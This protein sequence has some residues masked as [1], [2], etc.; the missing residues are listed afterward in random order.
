VNGQPRSHLARLNPD[1]SVESTATFVPLPLVTGNVRAIAVQRDGKILI[2]GDFFNIGG[3]PRGNIA[4]LNPDGTVE[5]TLTFDPGTGANGS[6]E[7]LAVQADG[8]IIIAGAFV[9]VNG[10]TRNNIA[11]LNPNGTLEN[12]TTFD[13][14][15]GTNLP[16]RSVALQADGKI[17]LGGAFNAVDSQF[18]AQIAR[19]FPNGLLEATTTFNP[20]DLD[21]DFAVS[22]I[23]VQADG[24]I[25]LAGADRPPVR[26][27]SNGLTDDTFDRSA[28]VSGVISDVALQADGRILLAGSFTKTNLPQRFALARLNNGPALQTIVVPSRTQVRWNRSGTAP[29]VEQVTFE[30]STNGGATWTLLGPGVRTAGGWSLGGLSLP[31]SGQIRA[32]GRTEAGASGV[33]QTVASFGFSVEQ[34]TG[35]ILSN[36]G[37]R[38]FSAVEIG[39]SKTLSF[40]V[41]NLGFE[42]LTGLTVSLEGDDQFGIPSQPAGTVAAGGGSTAFTVRF[43]PRRRG[44]VTATIRLR[45]DQFGDSTFDILLTAT[46]TGITALEALNAKLAEFSAEETTPPAVP[47]RP[48]AVTADADDLVFAILQLSR[49]RRF[50]TAANVAELA[51]TALQPVGGTTR[52]DKDQVAARIVDAALLGSGITEASEVVLIV[53]A[54]A[55][56]NAGDAR[57]ALSPAGKAAVVGQALAASN[58]ADAAVGAALAIVAQR[59]SASIAGNLSPDV[60]L[61]IFTVAVLKAAAGAPAQVRGFVNRTLELV[62]GDRDAFSIE[63]AVGVAA[64]PVISGEVLGVRA[65][66]LGSDAAI[67]ERTIAAIRDPR[68]SRAIGPI[69]AASTEAYRGDPVQF[70]AA[71]VAGIDP[72]SATVAVRAAIA[73]GVIQNVTGSRVPA[74]I[75]TVVRGRGLSRAELAAF[76][77]GAAVGTGDEA[78]E[79]AARMVASVANASNIQL[80]T[81]IAVAVLRAIQSTSPSS[82]RIVVRKLI[83][84][85]PGAFGT[86][87]AR[88]ALA[89]SLA[90]ALNTPAGAAAAGAGVAGVADRLGAPTGPT[91]T[92]LA[93]NVIPAAPNAALNI[94]QSL[95]EL[96]PA[97]SNFALFAAGIAARVGLPNAPK[98]AAGVA[99]TAAARSRVVGGQVTA[100][101][102]PGDVAAAVAQSSDALKRITPMIAGEIARAVHEER[103]AEIGEAVGA[104][105]RASAQP[106]GLPGTA[107]IGILA[108]RLADAINTRPLVPTANRVDELAELSAELTRQA[109]RTLGPR[110]AALPGTIS[111]IGISVMRTLSMPLLQN[112]GAFPADARDAA[113]RLA[114]AIAQTIS[115]AVLEGRLPNDRADALLAPG[116]AIEQNLARE[117][118][119]FAPNVRAAFTQVRGAVRNLRRLVIGA[120]RVSNVNTGGTIT[121]SGRY[122]IGSV[123]DAQA[124]F[125]RLP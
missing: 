103:V 22:A 84:S 68:L 113:G 61:R 64:F 54:V 32:R 69:V 74:V 25:L 2:A 8:K 109:I 107:S 50:A 108:G 53:N 67:I 60:K 3:Q 77:G 59:L 15:A 33:V 106:G 38:D 47:R 94:A 42:D 51:S 88:T 44:A 27:L 86:T 89:R 111:T 117:A 36:G 82:G 110:S 39:S 6:I 45:S 79:V 49:A 104:L 55:D 35:V 57:N 34:P 90:Q 40:T 119:A 18:R 97:R 93:V 101:Q 56:V 26:L 17:L 116:G 1:G 118:G 98:V 121:A 9:T 46:G 73:S 58:R 91:L 5:S 75:N 70:A 96:L 4:R 19:L 120:E 7:T 81:E 115:V 30:L 10:Q 41:R 23:A 87:A 83:D 13:P 99:L 112:G 65:A 43:T 37:S 12:L 125:G 124:T 11:R 80:R 122:E 105:Y 62:A 76:A 92:A 20:S 14:G 29:E 85:S 66:Q 63:V 100:G 21:V 16:V 28:I 123:I 71:L 114:G 72:A 52:A 95:S 24:R 78:A 31:F 102:T 48:T